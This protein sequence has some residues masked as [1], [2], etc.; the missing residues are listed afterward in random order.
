MKTIK[1]SLICVVILALFSGCSSII[2]VRDKAVASSTDVVTSEPDSEPES[3]S[4][5]DVTF[6]NTVEE[7]TSNVLSDG[8]TYKIGSDLMAGQYILVTDGS[9]YGGNSGCFVLSKDGTGSDDSII[10]IENFKNRSIVNVVNGQYLTVKNAG[11][12]TVME[13]PAVNRSAGVLPEGMYLVGR[14]LDAGTY[15]IR[16]VGGSAFICFYYNADHTADSLST[17]DEFSG[18]KKVTLTAGQ[19]IQITD[20][21]IILK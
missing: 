13:E 19:Y 2:T 9:G 5:P 11:V 7:P 21:E 15:T 16:S 3:V 10:K 17:T 14:N 4:A 8:T 6:P 18:D 12:Y 1:I 20:A